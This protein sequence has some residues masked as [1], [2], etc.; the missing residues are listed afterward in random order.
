M[1]HYDV[2]VIGSGPGGYIAAERAG[3]AGLKVLIIEKEQLGG[4]CTNWGCIPTKSLLNSA[5]L[6]SSAIHSA[7]FGVHMVDAQFKIN[8]AMAWKREVVATLQKGI[9]YLMKKNNVDVLFGEAYCIDASTVAVE[10]ERYSCNHLVIATGS[11]AMIP[12]VSGLDREMVM[13]NREILSLEEIPKTLV[14]I[15]GGMIGIEFASFY[16]QIGS[17]VHV[18]E[19]F[20]EVLPTIDKDCAK[21]VRREL[22][23][24]KFH[25]GCQVTEVEG[26]CVKLI[27]AQGR[28]DILETDAVLVS[29]GR[30]ANTTGLEALGLDI[31]KTGI[32]INERMQTNL[33]NVY[34][35]GDVTG[36]S[37]LAH[38]ASRMG[39]VAI[40]TILGKRNLM[41]YDAIPWAIYSLPEVAGCGLTEEEARK[42]NINVLSASVQMRSN[43]R[44]LAETGKKAGGLCK[45]VVNQETDLLLG[46]HLVGGPAS[47]II[48]GVA[49]LIEAELRV[50]EIKEIIFPHPSVSEIIKDAL[51]ALS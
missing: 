39:E 6:Y 8:E 45:V 32:I 50:N 9:A 11:S 49:S 37:L 30:K 38:S 4:V 27:D 48:Y 47:E 28:Q 10:G 14:I 29:V 21:L 33:P 17:Q 42:R 24:V 12:P 7:Q 35:V 5:K 44:F 43:G 34:A 18:V 23:Q 25:L 3:D 19:M 13:T 2:I 20:D 51:R 36:T 40:D 31:S 22:K 16:S 15:G 46:V 41:R 1:R 26:S